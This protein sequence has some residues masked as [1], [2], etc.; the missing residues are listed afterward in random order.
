MHGLALPRSLQEREQL[1][2]C[3]L[4]MIEER[5]PDDPFEAI[6]RLARGT[7][8]APASDLAAVIKSPALVA[9]GLG[10]K[11][12]QGK[13]MPEWLKASLIDVMIKANPNF[14]VREHLSRGVPHKLLGLIVEG[15]SE[16]QP[17]PE[18]RITLS[19]TRDA[20]GVP[21]ARVNWKIDLQARRSL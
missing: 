13:L 16:Q 19:D 7:S 17:D 15:I 20:L 12:F 8:P 21:R 18:S 9:K 6:K 11:A 3:A 5:A 14:M 4:Y 10:I 1:L 2:N